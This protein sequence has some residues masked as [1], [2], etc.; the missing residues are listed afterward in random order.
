MN[1]CVAN[2]NQ[3]PKCTKGTAEILM[4]CTG[5]HAFFSDTQDLKL[6]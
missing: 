5:K 4:V 2:S 3:V 6:C 1:S